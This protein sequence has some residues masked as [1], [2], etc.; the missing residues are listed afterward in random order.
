MHAPR[1]LFTAGH[2]VTTWMVS[3]RDGLREQAAGGLGTSQPHVALPAAPHRPS[4][5][6]GHCPVASHT[7]W[8]RW[9][10]SSLSLPLGSEPSKGRSHGFS[11]YL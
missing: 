5:R 7:L 2:P 6:P 8:G 10:V 4:C 1:V 11:C 9:H 3:V